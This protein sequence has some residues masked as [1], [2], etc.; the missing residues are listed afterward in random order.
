LALPEIG[1]PRSQRRRLEL[2][3]DIGGILDRNVEQ[4]TTIFGSLPLRA[5]TTP[6]LAENR[7]P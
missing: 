1:A 2:L 4:S 6:F 7:P 5:V 3:A